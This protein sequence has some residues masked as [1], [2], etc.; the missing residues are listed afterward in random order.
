MRDLLVV[1][2]IC[3]FKHDYEEKMLLVGGDKK[4]R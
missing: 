3:I 1:E 2:S 4:F